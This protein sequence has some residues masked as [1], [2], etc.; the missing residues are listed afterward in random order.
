MARVKVT[1]Y[2][3]KSNRDYLT[4]IQ[5]K[6]DLPIESFGKEG[7]TTSGTQKYCSRCRKCNSVYL[8]N[9]KSNTLKRLVLNL[10]KRC[11]VCGYDKCKS[12]LDYHHINSATKKFGL[13]NVSN[14]TED[15]IMTEI[16]KCVVLC[17][18]CHREVHAGIITQNQ[19]LDT[20]IQV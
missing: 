10:K 9:K 13:S 20:M 12:A 4:C 1:D 6:Q 14:V 11:V 2:I 18:R 3:P 8:L 15:E 7:K 17:C 16:G 5:C 19:L